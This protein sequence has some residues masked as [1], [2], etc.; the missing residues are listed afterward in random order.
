MPFNLGDMP[1]K[2]EGMPF[3]LKGMH[4]KSK[5]MHSKSKEM[6]FSFKG[7]PFVMKS[8]HPPLRGMHCGAGLW[9]SAFAR[10]RGAVLSNQYLTAEALRRGAELVGTDGAR[11]PLQEARAICKER[12]SH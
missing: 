2:S 10:P 12:T 9:C 6:P 4:F 1:S 11:I 8:L 3:N 7:V 5:G